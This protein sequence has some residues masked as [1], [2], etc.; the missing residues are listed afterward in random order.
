MKVY[1]IRNKKIGMYWQKARE[2]QN[3][4]SKKGKIYLNKGTA[5][6]VLKG[7]VSEIYLSRNS[8]SLNDIR[9]YY[10]DQMFVDGKIMYTPKKDWEVVEF[11][12]TEL[13]LNQ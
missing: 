3:T 11:K 8:K 10:G 9:S 2:G 6:L 7:Y 5:E 4:L 13:T 1:R 12:L